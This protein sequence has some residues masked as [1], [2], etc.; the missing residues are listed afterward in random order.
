MAA[1]DLVNVT[2]IFAEA[3]TLDLSSTSATTLVSNAASSGKLYMV[4]SVI[5]ANVDGTN[6][7]AITLTYNNQDD[8][9]GTAF[10]IA[11]TV[12]VPADASIVLIDKN[13]A[14]NLEED[15]SL[16]VTASAADDLEVICNYFI[17]DDA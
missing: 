11:S 15:T 17:M 1:P 13:T 4:T 10:A 8:G 3:V 2:S 5:V 12:T 14:V 9:G 6:D 16:V 7:A